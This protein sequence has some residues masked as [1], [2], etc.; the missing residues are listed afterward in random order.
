MSVGM[1]DACGVMF[2]SD[3]HNAYVLHGWKANVHGPIAHLEHFLGRSQRGRYTVAS[4]LG[5]HCTCL[6]G[7]LEGELTLES[8]P[9]LHTGKPVKQLTAL[10]EDPENVAD[11][12]S[13]ALSHYGTSSMETTALRRRRRIWQGA[14][15]TDCR[16]GR[17][18]TGIG[19]Q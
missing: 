5:S 17:I 7:S 19:G 15:Q 18:E 14:G 11:V 3:S 1:E 4:E 8:R 6:I 10:L 13:T 2:V 12:P 16:D 9:A